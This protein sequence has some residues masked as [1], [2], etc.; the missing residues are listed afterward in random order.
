MT[1][2]SGYTINPD[3]IDINQRL[4]SVAVHAVTLRPLVLMLSSDVTDIDGQ[5][6]WTTLPIGEAVTEQVT[7]DD[8]PDS[9]YVQWRSPA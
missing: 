9:V 2:S 7:D 3:H 4:G 6:V 5:A 1:D 8:R